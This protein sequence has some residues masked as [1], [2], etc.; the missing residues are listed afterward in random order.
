M[1]ANLASS[2]K[3]RT[4]GLDGVSLAG[5]SSFEVVEV[6]CWDVVIQRIL[7]FNVSREVASLAARLCSSASTK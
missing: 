3:Q 2:S 5:C 6:V 1:Q 4:H 7:P